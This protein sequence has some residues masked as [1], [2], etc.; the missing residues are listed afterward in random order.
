[1][2]ELMWAVELEVDYRQWCTLVKARIDDKVEREKWLKMCHRLGS[3]TASEIVASTT[4]KITQRG[5][6]R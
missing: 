1:M 5:I 4:A 3:H 2:G 6:A